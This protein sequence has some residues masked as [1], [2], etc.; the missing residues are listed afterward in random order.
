MGIKYVFHLHRAGV[1][2]GDLEK[3]EGSFWKQ[4]IKGDL[5][6][7]KKGCL[8]KKKLRVTLETRNKEYL[9]NK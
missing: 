3:N 9:G 1:I 2:Q 4:E 5:V 6:N 7:K 8:G